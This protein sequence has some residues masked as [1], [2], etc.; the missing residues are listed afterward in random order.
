[1]PSRRTSVH[2]TT[3]RRSLTTRRLAALAASLVAAPLLTVAPAHA[4]SEAKLFLD[5]TIAVDKADG[6]ITLPLLRGPPRR[7]P[8]LVRRHRVLRRRATPPAEG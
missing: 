3:L 1:M 2:T 8:G 4:G 7:R 6:T 5:S